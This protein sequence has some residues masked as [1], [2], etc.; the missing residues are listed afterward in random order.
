MVEQGERLVATC[1]HGVENGSSTDVQIK[2]A[3]LLKTP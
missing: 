3:C 1:W 2:D